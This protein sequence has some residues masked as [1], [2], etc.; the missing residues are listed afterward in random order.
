MSY[1]P[2]ETKEHRAVVAMELLR[3]LMLR[4]VGSGR[5]YTSID[6]DTL[7]EVLCVAGL[8]LV[9]PE[10][11]KEKEIDVINISRDEGVEDGDTV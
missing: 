4:E 3:F 7:N 11:V 2:Q 6:I 10:D 5:H 1:T 8:P 9:V